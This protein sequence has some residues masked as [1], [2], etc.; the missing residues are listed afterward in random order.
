MY[1]PAIISSINTPFAFL[2]FKSKK[3]A[4]QGFV[5]SNKR[6][7]KKDNIIKK[8]LF[9]HNSNGIECPINSS[10]TISFGSDV[11]KDCLIVLSKKK[12]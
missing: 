3:L 8:K 2:T 6:N 4:G 5:I 10:I 7:S 11:E 12:N 9:S 1:N